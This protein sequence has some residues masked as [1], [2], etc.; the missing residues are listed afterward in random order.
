MS[1][2]HLVGVADWA[3]QKAKAAEEKTKKHR[4]G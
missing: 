3:G 4:N 2:A 1:V